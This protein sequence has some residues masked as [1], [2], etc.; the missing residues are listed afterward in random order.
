MPPFSPGT[1]VL[2]Q[3][4]RVPS[5]TVLDLTGVT[6]KYPDGFSGS[7]FGL[8]DIENVDNVEVFGGTFDGGRS[9]RVGWN[10]HSH[11]IRVRSASNV[12]IHDNTLHNLSG[13]GVFV[14][15]LNPTDT[16]AVPSRGVSIRNN[17]FRGNN[18]NRQGVSVSHAVSVQIES[19]TLEGMARPDMPGAID[20]EPDYPHQNVEHIFVSN[21]VIRG[22]N[23]KPLGGIVVYNGIAAAP[24]NHI[25]ISQ[26]DIT[27]PFKNGLY[28]VGHDKVQESEIVV[29]G[30]SIRQ[31]DNDI[32]IRSMNVQ[33]QGTRT[34]KCNQSD[35]KKRRRCRR[36]NG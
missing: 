12:R 25:S 29:S 18:E 14:S 30:N 22:G 36:R 26:N 15:S 33:G 10:E 3:P 27:G 2:N 5:N 20:L 32:T 1:H 34:R 17:T 23:K 13:D 19:N 7:E 11:A 9:T 28:L 35:P 4:Y 31:T 16:A 8:L 21:N 6:L 24:M